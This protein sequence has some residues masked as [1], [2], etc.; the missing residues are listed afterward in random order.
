ML[1]FS[2]ADEMGLGKTVQIVSFIY[3]MKQDKLNP[4][5]I[6]IV[7]PKSILFQWE[8]VCKFLNF[9]LRYMALDQVTEHA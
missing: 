5:P 4:H 3:C 1:A 8:K 7:V 9:F 6:L 2:S